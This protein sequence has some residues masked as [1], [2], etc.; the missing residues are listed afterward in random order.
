MDESVKRDAYIKGLRLKNTG[1]DEEIIAIRLEKQGVTAELAREVAKNVCLQRTIDSVNNA[2]APGPFFNS[3]GAIGQLL[4][5]IKL[6]FK[7]KK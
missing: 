6:W 7:L 4:K 1:L 2:P 5:E 3:A